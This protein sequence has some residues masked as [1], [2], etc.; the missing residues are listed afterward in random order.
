MSAMTRRLFLQSSSVVGGVTLLPAASVRAYAANDKLNIAGIGVGGRGGNH[1]DSALAE[2]LVAACDAVEGTVSHCQRRVA[3]AAKKQGVDRPVPK[4]F[5]DYRAMLDAME[6]EIDAV[7]VATPDHHH[8][9][10]S[11]MA[12]K[13]KKHVY[14]EKP[15]THTIAESR[16]MAEVAKE[17]KVATQLGNQ[18]RAEEGWRALCEYVWAGAIGGVRE[19]HVWT[20]RPGIP[21]RPWW[22]QGGSRPAGEDP[23]PGGLHWDIWLGQAPVR[24]YLDS[25]KE[26]P[27]Q[28]KRVYQPFVWRGWWDF[29]TGAL[30]DIGCHA[31]SGICQ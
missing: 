16:R 30:G 20:D 1:V 24:P 15:L 17:T 26:G 31:L 3:E 18:H 4:P 28:G 19:V 8:A 6:K 27:F 11:L 5:H 25:Y 12:M 23:V 10:A 2:N 13:R 14:C 29:G 9:P 7:F 21:T 22:P